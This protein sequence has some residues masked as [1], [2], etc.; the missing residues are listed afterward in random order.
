MDY[1][2]IYASKKMR[3]RMPRNCISALP[4]IWFLPQEITSAVKD[5]NQLAPL[6]KAAYALHSLPLNA[7]PSL[8]LNNEMTKP[9]AG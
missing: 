1:V 4:G 2:V 9:G 5:T 3:K 8:P 6:S 7:L